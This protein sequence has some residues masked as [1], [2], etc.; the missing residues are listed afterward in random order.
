[1]LNIGIY[2]VSGQSGKAF[3]SDLLETEERIYG[4]ARASEHGS[5]EIEAISSRQGVS[6]E[7]RISAAET[8]K[9]IVP[10]GRNEVGHDLERLG[11]ESDLI[12]FSHPSIYHEE[13]ARALMPYLKRR[14]RP[15]PL[16]LSPSRTMGTPYLWQIL[17]NDYPV[18]SFQTCPYACK[19]FS[20]GSVFVKS[21]K[22]SWFASMEGC[23]DQSLARVLKRLF[24]PVVFSRRP[25]VTSLGNIG[26]VFHPAAYLLNLDAI[27][28]AEAARAT[29]SFY[30]QGISQN[31]A[32]AKVLE[33]IDQIRLKI[34]KSIGCSVFGQREDPREEEWAAVMSRVEHLDQ[35]K[36][37]NREDLNRLRTRY[38]RPIADS[39]VSAQCWLAYTYGV[40]RIP[41][42]SLGEAI[43]RTPNYQAQSYPQARYAHEDVPAGLT[44]L[45]SLA[46]RF[47]V[48]PSPISRIIDLYGR[49]FGMDARR[50]GRN[51]REFS[52]E[53]LRQYLLHGT[54]RTRCLEVAS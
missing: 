21:V 42:E 37:K 36:L 51:L 22:K 41:G 31:P 50:N 52:T 10:L 19:S 29:F 16:I 48:D 35:V 40:K 28:S 53:Y 9:E 25:A 6:R 2:G 47:G 24:P 3:L 38:M 8:R 23:F 39:V 17:G 7:R 1:M 13:T 15:V 46:A 45:E 20:P 54:V 18:V 12:I 14:P 44:P 26:A 30:M 11:M 5:A 34:A 32:V 49:T 33:E 27:R 4:Y 43:A